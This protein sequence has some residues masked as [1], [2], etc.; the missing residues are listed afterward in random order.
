MSQMFYFTFEAYFS[1]SNLVHHLTFGVFT[2]YRFHCTVYCCI[3]VNRNLYRACAHFDELRRR[4]ETCYISAIHYLVTMSSQLY[5]AFTAFPDFFRNATAKWWHQEIMDF[6]QTMKFD[7][8]WIV[9]EMVFMLPK[10]VRFTLRLKCFSLPEG[11]EWACQFCTWYSR[12]EVP[13]WPSAWEASV[14]A[15]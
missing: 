8:L 4:K 14:Y 6:Y 15:T 9:S 12:W 7:G 5:R 3:W 2:F 13:R 10:Y 11:H 1:K